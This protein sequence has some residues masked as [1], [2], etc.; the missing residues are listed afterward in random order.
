MTTK[1]DGY[2]ESGWREYLAENHFVNLFKWPSSGIPV[3][4]VPPALLD[5]IEKVK[6]ELA[7]GDWCGGE[8]YLKEL[9]EI[10]KEMK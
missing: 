8:G 9:S 7:S 10:E 5:W 4:L 2:L 3:C 1:P 6:R